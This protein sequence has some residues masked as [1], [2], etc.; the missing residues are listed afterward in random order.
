MALPPASPQRQPRHRRLIELEVFE[1]V[2]GLW[3]VDARLTDT[4][5]FD[6]RLKTGVRP[7]NTPLH[8]LQLRLVVD[9][10]FNI[11]DAGSQSAWTPYPEH[12]GEHGDAYRQLIGLNLMHGFRHAVKQRLSGVLGCTHLTE[13]A[14]LLPTAVVQ[15][16]AGT[17]FR[18]ADGAQQEG[19]RPFQLD[20]CHA[21][22]SSGDAAR[23]YYPRWYQ[24]PPAASATPSPTAEQAP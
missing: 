5:P 21:L 24:P 16:F 6:L 23:L 20:R 9:T 14:Q 7:A 17:V 2:D 18:A 1:R 15:A 3:E 11:L 22:R 13:L 12:C 4:K 19:A 8:E 10:G